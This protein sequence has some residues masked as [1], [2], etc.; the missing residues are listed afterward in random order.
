MA[1]GGAVTI[2][3]VTPGT[4]ARPEVATVVPGRA[5][6]VV[7]L[8]IRGQGRVPLNAVP[9][10]DGAWAN[11]FDPVLPYRDFLTWCGIQL[12]LSGGAKR[13]PSEWSSPGAV[14]QPVRGLLAE[15][16]LALVLSERPVGRNHGHSESPRD[17]T[18]VRGTV[19]VAALH[20]WHAQGTT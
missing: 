10:E 13:V 6:G 16:A 12:V 18:G 11:V 5:L 2:Y 14:P 7:L 8:E 15:L 3:R 4:K 17:P 20:R 1:D 19:D 9:T